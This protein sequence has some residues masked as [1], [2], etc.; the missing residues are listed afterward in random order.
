MLCSTAPL[1]EAPAEC[2]H[3]PDPIH[4]PVLSSTIPTV[5]AD[6]VVY[7]RPGVIGF[8]RL[9]DIF[10]HIHVWSTLDAQVVRGLCS[11]LFSGSNVAPHVVMASDQC[12]NLLLKNYA[13]AMYPGT[14]KPILLKYPRRRLYTRRDFDFSDQNLL[15][16]DSKPETCIVAAP[17]N[18]LFPDPWKHSDP[19][20]SEALKQIGEIC[21]AV[22]LNGPES[23]RQTMRSRR[24]KHN[25]LP[26]DSELYKLM[27][28]NIPYAWNQDLVTGKKLP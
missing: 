27:S 21:L 8:L 19:G 20:D 26:R 22:H 12:D 17:M 24:P 9:L 11:F 6:T 1:S 10:C 7:C 13:R 2:L 4:K 23:F 5:L 25:D 3:F 16:I 28:R 18:T 14:T 15:L